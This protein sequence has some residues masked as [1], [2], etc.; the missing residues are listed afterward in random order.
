MGVPVAVASRDWTPYRAV[1]AVLGVALALNL[2]TMNRLWASYTLIGIVGFVTLT[3][4]VHRFR[5]DVPAKAVW[6]VG[7]GA[8]LHYLGGSLSGLHT[9][10]GPNGAYYVFPW[11]DNVTHALGSGAVAVAAY[12]T[13]RAHLQTGAVLT[14]FLAVCVATTA[15][16][17]VELYEFAGFVFF[18]T[19][20]QGF[21]T[22][23]LLDLY[24]NLLGALIGTGV[25]AKW[26]T[27]TSGVQEADPVSST[28]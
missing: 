10:F 14:S 8:G 23:T 3:F 24:Y 20:D 25:Y 17:L 11:W 19:I 27:R 9:L 13:L 16:A 26:S 28:G 12:A 2:Y 1:G 4:L 18:H 15:G 7:V 5:W 6:L 21:Y 22:N